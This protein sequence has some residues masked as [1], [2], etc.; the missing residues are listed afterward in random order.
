MRCKLAYS[1]SG[2][3]S[4]VWTY[5]V[6]QITGIMSVDSHLAAGVMT[7]TIEPYIKLGWHTVPFKGKLKR[8]DN[9]KKSQIQ[10]ETDW[11]AKYR[12]HFNDRAA[13]LGGVITGKCSNI[14]AIDCDNTAT[15]KL[16][17]SLDPDYSFVFVS[18][19]KKNALG[20]EQ[21]ACTI[22]YNYTEELDESYKIHNNHLSLD[23]MSNDRMVFL[24]GEDN[25]TK[26]QFDPDLAEL[27]DAPESII[28][29][30]KSLKPVKLSED[31]VALNAKTYRKHLGPQVQRLIDTK[32]VI[33]EL[34]KV[35]TPKDFRTSD[36]YLDKGFLEPND[37]PDGRGSEYLSK[38]SGIL[39]ADESVD[40]ELY[41]NAIEIINDLFSDPMPKSR[42]RAT[43]IEPMVEERASVNGEVIWQFNK[44]WNENKVT[45]ITKRNTMMDL[46]FDPDRMEYFIVDTLAEK[47]KTFNRD[48]EYFSYV[49]AISID[50][51]SKKEAKLK[52][53]LVNT[54][55]SPAHPYGFFNFPNSS[56]QS[57]NTFSATQALKIFKEPEL[58]RNKYSYPEITIKY[59]ES[60]IPD[61]YMR[62][63]LLRFLRRKFDKFEYSPV[64]IYLL[65]VSGA[66]KDTLV[67]LIN[68]IIGD[69]GLARPSVKEF[70]EIYNSWVMD[71]Y[72]VQL[73]EYGN[74]LTRFDEKESALG[75]IKAWTGK[76]E[77]QIRQMRT[78]GFQYKHKFTFIMTAN[79]NPL[80]LDADDRRVA[81]FNCPNKMEHLS[82][83]QSHGGVSAVLDSINEEIY[84]FAY[85]LSTGVENLTKDEYMQPP[86]TA[87]KMQ[88]IASKLNAGMRIA[89]YLSNKMFDELDILCKEYGV[90]DIFAAAPEGRI[91]EDDLFDLYYEMTDSKGTKRGLTASLKEFDKIPTTKDGVKSYYYNIPYLR[92]YK[93]AAFEPL[94]EEV[95]ASSV[96][97]IA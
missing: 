15:T 80:F 42:L 5:R 65:G 32:K 90:D 31:A 89:F 81:L 62:N 86:Q 50:P 53:P 51:P 83:V 14:I 37:V 18:V 2:W 77:I 61:D 38:V 20:V 79:K 58:Y 69:N 7:K 49:E 40:E 45:V 57:F 82:W 71:K 78:D 55:S 3:T 75:K 74:Q 54:V 73:D 63:Y 25:L 95:E 93:Q 48:A 24:P 56:E 12:E 1:Q 92:G 34:F 70:L 91:Y 10:F 87:D 60:L 94:D 66:G 36:A 29:L 52:L 59:L 96:K 43:I 64:I 76:Q 21:E 85:F 27:K 97:G 35:L 16:F 88:L 17:R 47:A 84:D 28:A 23:F 22:I 4:R 41:A 26:E 72:F 44:N 33:P 30:L 13:K 46:F 19:G 6:I 67:S 39:G 11:L 9:G 8:L 68:E